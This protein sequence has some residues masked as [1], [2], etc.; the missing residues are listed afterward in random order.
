MWTNSPGSMCVF[1]I[2]IYEYIDVYICK[3]LS[4]VFMLKCFCFVK[5]VVVA[6]GSGRHSDLNSTSKMEQSSM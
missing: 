6:E 2:Y 5:L 3:Y 1:C 4:I